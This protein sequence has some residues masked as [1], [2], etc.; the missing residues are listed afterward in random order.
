MNLGYD[1]SGEQLV[2]LR[3]RTVGYPCLRSGGSEVTRIAEVLVYGV[4]C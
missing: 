3:Q 4:V 2:E 1:I